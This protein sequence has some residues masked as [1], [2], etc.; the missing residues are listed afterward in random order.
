MAVLGIVV[1]KPSAEEHDLPLRIVSGQRERIQ[2][3]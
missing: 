1:S 3:E 2:G